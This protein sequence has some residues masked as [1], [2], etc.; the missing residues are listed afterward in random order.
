MVSRLLRSSEPSIRYKALV[1]L[2]GVDPQSRGAVELGEEIRRSLRVRTLLS[3]KEKDGRI[4][5][6]PYSKWY[7]AHWILATLA[8]L[9]YPQEDESLIPMRDQVYEWLFSPEHTRETK[10]HHVYS[11]PYKVVTGRPR[12]H[13]SL[14]GN[15]LFSSLK[16]GIWNERTD[17]LAD[18]LVSTQWE[19]GG[20]NCDKTPGANHSSF[21]ESLIPLRGLLYHAKIRKSRSSFQAAKKAAEFFLKR[22][23]F[24]TLHDG[25]II[26]TKFLELH[27]PC[28]WHYDILFALKV[29]TE[30][31]YIRDPRCKEALNLLKSRNLSD[32]GFPADK[33]FYTVTRDL[34]AGRSLVDW[35]G[36][37]AGKMNEFVTVDALNV[38]K[39]AE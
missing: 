14:E 18:R 10:H 11:A 15:A 17:E 36:V 20:W 19:D 22:K 27:Y 35:G 33:K 26:S 25:T 13:A 5:Y 31:S 28:Y 7:G 30:G 29:M 3:E 9:D 16:L 2:F 23:L 34:R 24:R 6:H 32:G 38:L 37:G 8:D 4:R 1:G 12:I 21:N 39:A